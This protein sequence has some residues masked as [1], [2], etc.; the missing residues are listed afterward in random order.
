[1]GGLRSESLSAGVECRDFLRNSEANLRE[2]VQIA[3]FRTINNISK[4]RRQL[5]LNTS[6]DETSFEAEGLRVS[7]RRPGSCGQEVVRSQPS[8]YHDRS[9]KDAE[10]HVSVLP[11][12]QP[13]VPSSQSCLVADKAK[14][15]KNRGTGK[16]AMENNV[17]NYGQ[18]RQEV[19]FQYQLLKKDPANIW[20]MTDCHSGMCLLYIRLMFRDCHIFR[21]CQ[22]NSW[23]PTGYLSQRT[24][25]SNRS[26]TCCD[27]H[28]AL[29][30]DSRDVTDS[31]SAMH[32]I[33]CTY[34]LMDVVVTLLFN[35][36]HAVHWSRFETLRCTGV[37][38]F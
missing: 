29:C 10:E 26:Q 20:G 8:A 5:F 7:H 15:S 35:P 30:F 12:C 18:Q 24:Q 11:I 19:S 33:I 31:M 16:L 25:G 23:I 1:M 36:L 13:K 21:R 27:L 32:L 6:S 9:M 38:P 14:Q 37:D 2:C 17:E 4:Y 22:I 28:K 3:M 34:F